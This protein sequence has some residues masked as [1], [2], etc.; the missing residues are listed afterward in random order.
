MVPPHPQRDWLPGRENAANVQAYI[1]YRQRGT[2][3]EEFSMKPKVWLIL[4]ANDD[5]NNTMATF[6]A[7]G[8]YHNP[9]ILPPYNPTHVTPSSGRQW[10]YIA[11]MFDGQVAPNFPRTIAAF[12]A[13]TLGDWIRFADFHG[14][15]W[16]N[17]EHN[18]NGRRMTVPMARA[19]FAVRVGV[20]DKIPRNHFYDDLP[21]FQA[22]V[23]IL[24]TIAAIGP[25][26]ILFPNPYN[27]NN[28]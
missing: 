24:A 21:R 26:P 25:A 14:W 3:P 8:A 2:R 15:D 6:N 7:L 11:R 1:H 20:F 18:Q 4:I 5:R 17:W 22:R 27:D 10:T 19:K 23:Q 16:R 9:A 28:L 12:L 13:M